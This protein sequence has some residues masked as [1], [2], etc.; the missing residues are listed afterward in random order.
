MDTVDE[1]SEA[2]APTA[3]LVTLEGSIVEEIEELHRQVMRNRAVGRFGL[4]SGSSTTQM[5][6]PEAAQEALLAEHGFADYD[7]FCRRTGG[8]TAG[9][10]PHH[11]QAAGTPDPECSDGPAEPSEIP[12]GPDSGDRIESLRVVLQTRADRLVAELNEE[13]ERRFALILQRWVDEFAEIMGRLDEGRDAVSALFATSSCPPAH[14]AGEALA[15]PVATGDPNKD[16]T[17]LRREL[18]QLSRGDTAASD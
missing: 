8:S 17:A 16:T 2:G 1:A 9:A 12:L 14:S 6:E 5:E 3:A 10:Q 4:W 13:L 11:A 15:A 18:G 7:D